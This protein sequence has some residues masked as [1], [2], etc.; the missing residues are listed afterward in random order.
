M[1]I[2]NKIL[3]CLSYMQL[4]KVLLIL[5]NRLNNLL[6]NISL[7]SCL[8]PNLLQSE[9]DLGR[10]LLVLWLKNRGGGVGVLVSGVGL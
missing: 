10:L 3:L 1:L 2:I 7:Y 4:F 8:N 6:L 5:K 9:L